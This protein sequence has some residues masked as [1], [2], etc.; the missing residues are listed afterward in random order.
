MLAEST[1]GAHVTGDA[2]RDALLLGRRISSTETCDVVSPEATDAPGGERRFALLVFFGDEAQ[3]RLLDHG[4]TSVVGREPPCEIVV[5]DA[6]IS[7]RHARFSI[8]EGAVWVEDLDSR[9][10]TLLRGQRVERVRLEPGDEVQ[11]GTVRLVL[12]ATLSR[13]QAPEAGRPEG[14]GIEAGGIEAAR[15][16]HVIRN[17]LMQKLYADVDRVSRTNVPVLVLGETGSGKEHVANALHQRGRPTGPFVVAN[18]AAIPPSLFEATLFGHE[19]GAFTGAVKQTLGLFERAHGGTLFLDE[20]GELAST[21]Q[22]ALLRAIETRRITRVGASSEVAVDVR[23]IAA[24]HCDLE[25]MTA[26]G[27][28][29]Q[30]L[31][32]RLNGVKFLVPPLRERTDEIEPLVRLFIERARS[33]W[34]VTVRDIAADAL[35]VLGGYAWPGNIR[36]LHHAV[37]RAALLSRAEKINVGDLPDYVF[38]AGQQPAPIRDFFESLSDLTLREQLA[39]FEAALVSEALR[40]AGGNRVAAAKLLRIPVRTLFRKIRVASESDKEEDGGA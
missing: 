22:A 11:V 23:L 32:F 20:I 25:A 1:T 5:R 12:A 10:G 29:R 26:D 2:A 14:G 36:Q 19:R 33:D 40:R 34:G 8:V 18:C 16:G 17:A 9:N 7:R 27:I 3:V 31:Y 13:E 39:R 28:F 37:E 15:S 21:Q 24:T 4:S 35:N 30:D 6:S 38:S